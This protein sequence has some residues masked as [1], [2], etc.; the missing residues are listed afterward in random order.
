MIQLSPSSL[1]RRPL[2][3]RSRNAIFT[4]TFYRH[5]GQWVFD[6]PARGIQLEPLV[7]GADVLF[8][9]LSGRDL[10]DTITRCTVNF[11]T[12]PI[13]GHEVAAKFIGSEMEGSVYQVTVCKTNADIIDFRFWLCPA[14][15]AYYRRAPKTLYV[16][17]VA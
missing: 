5:H 14:L 2:F 17:R 6:D 4:L 3:R 7:S 1:L 11:S 13:P 12:T 10:D 15:F 9:V 8:D 16:Q